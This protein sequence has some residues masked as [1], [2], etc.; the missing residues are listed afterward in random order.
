VRLEARS[1]AL[2]SSCPSC[3]AHRSS[4][5]TD[6]LAM[7][8]NTGFDTDQIKDKARKDLLYLLEGVRKD[9]PAFL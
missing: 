1:P 2:S 9:V 7:A 4:V 8:P 3:H 6:L 5:E